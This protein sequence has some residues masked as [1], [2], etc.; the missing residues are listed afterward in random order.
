MTAARIALRI[1]FCCKALEQSTVSVREGDRG[2]NAYCSLR[3]LE[4]S[5][6]RYG[7]KF[8]SDAFILVAISFL[9]IVK[10]KG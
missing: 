1:I 7:D 5:E 10:P 6:C 2:D 9:E 8:S 4:S 3:K